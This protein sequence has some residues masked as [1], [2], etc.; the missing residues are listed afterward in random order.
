MKKGYAV[1][2]TSVI[3]GGLSLIQPGTSSAAPSCNDPSPI[4]GS[5]TVTGPCDL[6]GKKVNGSI[7]VLS[8]GELTMSDTAVTGSV[9]VSGGTIAATNSSVRGSL[10]ITS[11]LDGAPNTFCGGSINGSLR[12]SGVDGN[13]E[14]DSQGYFSVGGP[15]N[16]N[17]NGDEFTISGSV[18][19]TNNEGYVRL[20]DATVRGSVTVTNNRATSFDDGTPGVGSADIDLNTIKGSLRC[21]NNERGVDGG[22]NTVTGATKCT[23]LTP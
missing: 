18:T 11:T 21:S 13:D 17:C 22:M 23:F 3:F 19:F 16:G 10:T 20:E 2:L 12:V 8:G 9:T 1:A 5:L 14:T 4:R 6:T 7:R 15:D